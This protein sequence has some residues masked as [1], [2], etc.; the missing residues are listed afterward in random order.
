MLLWFSLLHFLTVAF[1]LSF[2]MASI[3]P[4]RVRTIQA[5]I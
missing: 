4:E 3:H 5:E 1:S 2:L